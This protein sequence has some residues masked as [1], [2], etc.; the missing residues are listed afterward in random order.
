VDFAAPTGTPVRAAADGLV[1]SAGWSGGYGKVIRL[2][3]KRGFETLYG[4]LLKIDVKRGQRVEQGQRIGAV[5]MTGLATGP[6]LDYRTIRAGAF[7]NPLTI[8]PPAAEPVSAS[9][10]AAFEET[11]DR[12]L[13]LLEPPAPAPVAA[14]VAAAAVG[15][16]T[17]AGNR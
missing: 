8:Q 3:H 7:V 6:H 10:R 17:S 1:V 12:E 5:G 13:A 16:V 14:A 4:H 15:G 11:R 2:R 9:A